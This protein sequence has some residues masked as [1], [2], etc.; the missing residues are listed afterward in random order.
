MKEEHRIMG[1]DYGTARIGV[2]VSDP[3]GISAQPCETI[4]YR[5]DNELWGQLDRIQD[6]MTIGTI[7]LGLPLNMNGSEGP[8]AHAVH[9]FADKLRR[10][11]PVAVE[12][13]DERLSTR[14]A[15]RT[16]QALGGRPSRSRG[17]VDQVAAV[18]ILQG[19]LDRRGGSGPA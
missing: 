13:W 10:R 1:L 9:V 3:L 15:E 6:D 7:V 18:W 12:L 4:H 8:S 2:A 5:S 19:F 14:A 16:I 11:Y 17:R